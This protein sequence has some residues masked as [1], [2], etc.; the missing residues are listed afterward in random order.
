[1]VAQAFYYNLG[2][3]FIVLVNIPVVVIGLL[4]SGS[5]AVTLYF[6]SS[7]YHSRMGKKYL[8]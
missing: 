4:R 8:I 3:I 6:E 7:K 5:R 2:V 1:M